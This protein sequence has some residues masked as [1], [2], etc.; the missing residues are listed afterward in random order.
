[1]RYKSSCWLSAYAVIMLVLLS[2]CGQT[3]ST[4]TDPGTNPGV[5]DPHKQYTVNL[6][7]TFDAGVNKTALAHLVKQYTDAHKNVTINIQSYDSYDTLVTKLDAAIAANQ[8]PAIAQVDDSNATLYQEDGTIVPLQPYIA[9][10]NGLSQADLSDFYAALLKDGQINGEQYSLPWNKS[11]EVLYYNATLLKKN[12]MQPP[13]TL[14][15]FVADIQQLTKSDGSQWG[16]SLTPGV[17][18][19][20][21]IFKDLGGKN[22]ISSA[23]QHML[24]NQ[25][26]DAQ[27]AQQALELFAPLVQTRAI[28]I[29]S[30]SNWQD[31]FTSQKAAFA[32]GS[33]ASY[34]LLKAQGGSAFDLDEAA[35]PGGPAGQFTVLYGGSNLALFSGVNDDT[36]NAAWDFMKFLLSTASNIAFVQQTGYMPIRQSAF[37]SQSLQGYYAQNPGSTVGLAQA[38]HA[39]VD[40]TL[41]IWDECIDYIT[42][43]YLSVLDGQSTA[44]AALK[45]MAQLCNENI[46]M[47]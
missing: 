29:T 28:H 16:L 32:L 36:R 39:Y 13:T 26:S 33:S 2:A 1:M 47:A 43:N 11:D 25:G 23:S 37:T 17:D 38:S 22:F 34:P 14:T 45:H 9:G 21:T 41:P 12:N 35:F 6:W 5:L 31:D 10:N 46:D 7:E 40:S 15:D 44:A 20:S 18:E 3:T 19:W 27:Y 8:P 42:T 24:F 30:G 4:N